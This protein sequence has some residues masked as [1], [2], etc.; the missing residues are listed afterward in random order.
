MRAL[1]SIESYVLSNDSSS[2]I[3]MRENE[4]AD[5]RN[6]IVA[7]VLTLRNIDEQSTHARLFQLAGIGSTDA[8]NVKDA[9]HRGDFRCWLLPSVCAEY[10]LHGCRELIER[11][12]RMCSKGEL[13]QSL[14]LN[15]EY[16]VQVTKYVRFW[17]PFLWGCA[18]F[19]HDYEAN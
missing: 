17:M 5:I 15:G 4:F 9:K 13:K 2:P 16:S 10:D 12:T 6:D 8:T 19:E 1:S 7:D 3:V 18:Q 14:G 11:I